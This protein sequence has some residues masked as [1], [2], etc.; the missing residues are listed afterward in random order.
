[1]NSVLPKRHNT[2]GLI[3]LLGLAAVACASGGSGAPLP[4]LEVPEVSEDLGEGDVI[5]VRVFREPDL[6]G[7]YQIGGSATLDFPLVGTLS[8]EGHTPSSLEK[9]IEARLE[10][11]FL[12]D[13]QVTVLVKERAARK[14]HVLG[15]VNKPGSFPYEPGMT[16][17]QAITNAGGFSPLAAQNNVTVTRRQGEAEESFNVKVGSIQSGGARNVFLYPRD[18]VYVREAVF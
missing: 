1:M 13:A 15:A 14:V 9:L 18:I 8:V 6:A 12:V 16:I 3:F 17:I 2:R 4:N 10:D 11:G 5:E 7:V